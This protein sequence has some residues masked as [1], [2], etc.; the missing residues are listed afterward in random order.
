MVVG[1]GGGDGDGIQVVARQQLLEIVRV[2]HAEL[3]GQLASALSIVVPHRDQL[4][5]R[6]LSG[7]AGI[8]PGVHMPAADDRYRDHLPEGNGE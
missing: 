4:G 5:F 7:P 8:V 6:M 1:G 2:R 3:R